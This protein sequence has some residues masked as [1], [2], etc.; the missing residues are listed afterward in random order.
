[1]STRNKIGKLGTTGVGEDIDNIWS[2]GWFQTI[3]VASP[4]HNCFAVDRLKEAEKNL[5]I[6]GALV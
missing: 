3:A 2:N 4:I 5:V 1:L 6:G